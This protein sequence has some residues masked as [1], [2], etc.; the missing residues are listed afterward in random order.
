MEPF[1]TRRFPCFGGCRKFR[2]GYYSVDRRVCGALSVPSP[3]VFFPCV[4]SPTPLN[5][6]TLSLQVRGEIC[7][8]PT[9]PTPVPL[10]VFYAPK[11]RSN[12]S[13]R[14]GTFP[15]K[16]GPEP[17]RRPL[18]V[19]FLGLLACVPLLR[20]HPRREGAS[21]DTAAGLFNFALRT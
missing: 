9:L 13:P 1:K 6:T 15:S 20:L 2:S 11:R 16:E 21:P 19:S 4:R 8:G 17:F 14:P 10:I 5:L 3:W 7:D 12:P 18:E